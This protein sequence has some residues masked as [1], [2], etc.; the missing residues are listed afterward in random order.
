ML[1]SLGQTFVLLN[2]CNVEQNYYLR[3]NHFFHYFFGVCENKDERIVVSD[4]PLGHNTVCASP[5]FS[6]F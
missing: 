5:F 6:A 4:L 2:R 1:T 3:P